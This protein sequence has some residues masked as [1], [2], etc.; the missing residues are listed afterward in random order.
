[1]KTSITRNPLAI[2]CGATLIVFAVWYGVHAT[3]KNGEEA[4]HRYNPAIEENTTTIFTDRDALY[5]YIKKFGPKKTIERLNQLSSLYGSCHDTAHWAGRFAYELYEDQ[6]FK[7]CSS[8]CHSGCYHGATEVFFKE[9]G[10]ANLSENLQTLC[11][12]DLNPFFSHQCFHGIGHGLMAWANYEIFDALEACDLL[13]ERKDSCWT[14]VFMENIVGS[15]GGSEDGHFTNYLSDDPYYPCDDPKLNDK[16]KSSCYFLQT[17]RM[18]DLFQS[19]FKKIAAACANAPEAYRVSCFGSM[20]RDVRG[21]HRD[22]PSAAIAACG[23]APAGSF[24]IACLNGASQ[25]T[26][27]DPTGQD[28]ALLFCKLLTNIT[29]KDPCYD[30]IFSRAPNVFT[31]KSDHEAF[32]AKAET[33]YQD[34]CKTYIK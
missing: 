6:A 19:D 34:K 5:S 14:G 32:C 11:S 30:T 17:S 7:E 8:E 26:F 31:K 4:K 33:N 27:W 3:S 18:M 24:R 28:T 20:G 16:Y 10:T 25:D 29:E 12:S 15:L 2:A 22:S 9:N 23:F 1:M 13:P 21:S